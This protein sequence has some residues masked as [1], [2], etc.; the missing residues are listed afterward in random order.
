MFVA[1]QP[2]QFC[3]RGGVGIEEGVADHATGWRGCSLSVGSC[4]AAEEGPGVRGCAT[5]PVCPG[6]ASVSKRLGQ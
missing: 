5:E 6:V 1:V 2:S 3:P 4:R